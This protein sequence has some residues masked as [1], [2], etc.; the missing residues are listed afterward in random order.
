MRTLLVAVTQIQTG[1]GSMDQTQ[2]D[3]LIAS[4]KVTAPVPKTPSVYARNPGQ[5]DSN[6]IINYGSALGTKRYIYATAA[7]SLN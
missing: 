2:I 1:Q 4:I 5:V 7:F 3:T 6:S